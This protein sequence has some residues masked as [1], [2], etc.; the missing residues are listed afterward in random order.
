[1]AVLWQGGVD[2]SALWLIWGLTLAAWVASIPHVPFRRARGTAGLLW[3][4]LGAYTA[5]L[6]IPLPRALVAAVHPAAVQISDASRAALG[7][8]AL[9]RLAIALSPGDAAMQVGLYLVCGAFAVLYGHGLMLPDSRPRTVRDGDWVS[10]LCAIAAA[11]WLM[12]YG[13]WVSTSLPASLRAALRNWALINPNHIAGLC[14]VGVAFAM[15]RIRRSED[16]VLRNAYLSLAVFLGGTAVL[17]G[18][19]GGVLA[20]IFVVAATLASMKFSW[21]RT[22]TTSD[23]IAQRKRVD[24]MLKVLTATIVAALLSIPFIEAEILPSF[25]HGSSDAKLELFAVAGEHVEAGWL[26]GQGPGAIPVTLGIARATTVKRA[27]FTENLVLERFIDQGLWGSVPFFAV[28][29][30]LMVSIL[31]TQKRGGPGIAPWLACAGLLLQNLADFSL[32]IAGGLLLFLVAASQAE[33]LRTATSR[34]HRRRE[35]S[36]KRARM[37][38]LGTTLA[39]LLLAGVA[40]ASA[41]DAVTRSAR[42]QLGPV[43]LAT[44]KAL[45]ADRFGHDHHAFFMLCR[46]AAEQRAYKDAFGLCSRALDLWPSSESARVVRFAAGLDAGIDRHLTSDL[47]ALLQGSRQMRERTL[48]ICLRQPRAEAALHDALAAAPATSYD[49]GKYVLTRRPDLVEGLAI[50]LREAHPT[51]VHGIEVLRGELYMRR[52]HLREAD[53]IATTLLGQ[54]GLAAHGW[55]LQAQ[56]YER[57]KR[58]K[59]ALPLFGLACQSLPHGHRSCISAMRVAMHGLPANAALRYMRQ[60]FVGV[61]G[62]ASREHEYWLMLGQV[63]FKKGAYEDAVAAA[64]R[65]L[66]LRKG[67]PAALALAA[68]AQLRAGDWRSAVRL[69]EQLPKTGEWAKTRVDLANEV[70]ETRRSGR[71]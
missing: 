66:G 37:L 57:A 36:T 1:M 51:Q 50:R 4:G 67:A 33:R 11:L 39:A 6:L 7:Y 21:L 15:G 5:L 12:S 52:N 3:I 10:Y 45:V 24:F 20:V 17:S 28:L 2:L 13:R 55:E 16:V 61:R 35:S 34:S 18:S 53:R 40:L 9:E 47:V 29:T 43:D 23:E 49:V 8:P 60:H 32:E 56:I 71:L 70:S 22:R 42:S 46:K 25:A 38:V 58:Y 68:T 30:W 31:V 14:V 62:N 63:F 44:G 26:L 27:D 59:E 54:P 65:A 41:N 69:L 64:Q 48:D 19:R